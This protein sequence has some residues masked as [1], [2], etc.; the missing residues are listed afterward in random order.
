MLKKFI[1]VKFKKQI[2]LQKAFHGTLITACLY[3]PS[4]CWI[5]VGVGRDSASGLPGDSAC[6]K[7]GSGL[8][9][10]SLSLRLFRFQNL[11]SCDLLRCQIGSLP[12]LLAEKGDS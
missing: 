11:A 7:L 1:L 12:K 9:G 2:I 5:I 3:S 10:E 6:A 4:S 8:C